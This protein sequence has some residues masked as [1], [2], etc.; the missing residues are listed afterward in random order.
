M[1]AY[2]KGDVED[3]RDEYVDDSHSDEKA[4]QSGRIGSITGRIGSLSGARRKSVLVDDV[5]GEIKEGGVNYRDVCFH[6]ILEILS[7]TSG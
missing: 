7:L 3:I 2:E 4:H 6:A 5:F 1:A